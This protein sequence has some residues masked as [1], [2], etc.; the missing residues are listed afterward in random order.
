[1]N[2]NPGGPASTVAV[3]I[4]SQPT[5]KVRAALDQAAP[6]GAVLAGA[7][8]GYGNDKIRTVL[9]ELVPYLQAKPNAVDFLIF[10]SVTALVWFA[11]NWR[12]KAAAYPVLDAPNQPIATEPQPVPAALHVALE[13]PNRP[14]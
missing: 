2:P 13:R 6:L 12:G 1:M 3:Q 11:V 8:A 10:V 7:I 5:N 4:T 9:I 14:V